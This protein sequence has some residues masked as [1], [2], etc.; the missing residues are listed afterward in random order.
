MVGIVRR[1][2]ELGR[3]VI[4]REMRKT[5]RLKEGD[6]IEITL[7]EAGVVLKKFSPLKS[8]GGFASVTAESL[9][10]EFGRTVVVVDTDGVLAASGRY[11]KQFKNKKITEKLS[12]E[13]SSCSMSLKSVFDGQETG[14]IVLG[15]TDEF[16]NRIVQPVVVGGNVVGGIVVVDT[17]SEKPAA[18]VIRVVRFCADFLARQFEI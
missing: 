7:G 3:I 17:E 4:P 11:E 5:L 13:L 8:L 14:R 2:D 9:A 15:E 12:D 10:E 1:I 18:E 6:P 16:S